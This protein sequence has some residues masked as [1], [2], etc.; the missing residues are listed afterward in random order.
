M[1]RRPFWRSLLVTFLCC[2]ALYGQT[3]RAQ[4]TG[5]VTD[6]SG[7]VILGADLAATNIETGI[8]QKTTS[9]EQG[10]YRLLN[11]QPGQYRLTGRLAGFKTFSQQPITLQVGGSLTMNISLQV[12]DVADQVTVVGDASLI[13]SDSSSFGQVVNERAIAEMPLSVCNPINLVVMTPGVV[14]GSNFGLDGLVANVEQGRE[15]WGGDFQIGRREDPH[16]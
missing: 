12:G 8:S 9:N 13:E 7:A 16:E 2:V 6:P 14:T 1:D 10:I 3:F 4:L 11:L 15:Q 5:V